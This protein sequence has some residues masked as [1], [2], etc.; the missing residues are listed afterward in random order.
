MLTAAQV[1]SEIRASLGNRTDLDDRLNSI[2][3]MSQTR[4]ARL[5]DFDELRVL[6]SINTAVTADP[7]AD[8]II[9]LTSLARYRKIYSIRAYS[10]SQLSRKLTKVLAKRWDEQIPEPEYYARG[11]P[12]HYTLWGKDQ[13]ELWK[14]PDAVYPLHFRY[15]RWPTLVTDAT[16]DD[17]LDLEDLDDA[18]IHLSLSYCWLSLGNLEKSNSFFSIYRSLVKDAIDVETEDYDLTQMSH[19]V[20]RISAS[21]GYDDPFVRSTGGGDM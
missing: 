7:A 13:L 4:I 11:V 20:S 21:R 3:N 14:V 9:S 2:I 17:E 5:H 1:K 12:T 10:D 16:Q 8:K 19:D 18:I 6:T 15:S